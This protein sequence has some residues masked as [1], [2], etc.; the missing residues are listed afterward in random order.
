MRKLAEENT[1]IL[2]GRLAADSPDGVEAYFPH[3]AKSLTLMVE[4]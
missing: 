3:I 2:T 1:L 4:K